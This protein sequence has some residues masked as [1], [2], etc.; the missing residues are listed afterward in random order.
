MLATS[1]GFTAVA[2][3]SLAL[4][5]GVNTAVFSAVDAMLFGPFLTTSRTG[6]SVSS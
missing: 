3:L 5:I 4:G 1:R 6:W 2:V